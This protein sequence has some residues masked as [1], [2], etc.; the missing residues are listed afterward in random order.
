M[1]CSQSWIA[2]EDLST[3]TVVISMSAWVLEVPHS[4]IIE[5]LHGCCSIGNPPIV[6]AIWCWD[7]QRWAANGTCREGLGSETS[8]G[9]S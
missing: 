6:N 7:V 1:G 5:H 2:S 9:H 3:L 4:S 8:P